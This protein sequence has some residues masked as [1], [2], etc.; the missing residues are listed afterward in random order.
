MSIFQEFACFPVWIMS[1]QVRQYP[2]IRIEARDCI[3]SC[4]L[5]LE[6]DYSGYFHHISDGVFIWEIFE[7][8]NTY[9]VEVVKM[10][11]PILEKI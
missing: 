11:V 8:K 5:Y 7:L 6:S 4:R 3:V 1:R 10:L 9:P 2:G